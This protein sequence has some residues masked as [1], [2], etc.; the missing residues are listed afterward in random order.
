MVISG[1]RKVAIIY[2]ARALQSFPVSHM[3]QFASS[4]DMH[5]IDPHGDRN[6]LLDRGKCCVA[7]RQPEI[8]RS[9]QCIVFAWYCHALQEAEQCPET[10]LDS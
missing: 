10:T 6:F 5:M 7:S 3:G 2:S 8:L 4:R 1:F 9:R